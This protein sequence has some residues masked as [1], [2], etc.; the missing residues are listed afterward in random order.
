[1]VFRPSKSTFI[2]S[3]VVHD[4]VLIARPETSSHHAKKEDEC[5]KTEL[6]LRSRIPAYVAIG[7]YAR[8]CWNATRK[9][10]R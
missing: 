6:R 7:E 1:M 9:T 2:D 3:F 5:Y 8:S 10:G 4:V